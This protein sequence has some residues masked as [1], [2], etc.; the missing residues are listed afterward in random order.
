MKIFFWRKS[1]LQ[2]LF[3]SIF[4]ILFAG[5]RVLKRDETTYAKFNYRL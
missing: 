3:P 1:K 4:S 2:N 5:N